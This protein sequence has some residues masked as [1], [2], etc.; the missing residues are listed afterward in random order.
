M[1]EIKENSTDMKQYIWVYLKGVCMGVADIIPGVSGGT[2]AFITGIYERLI[3]AIKSI[4]F[5]NLKLLFTGKIKQFWKNVD[6]A[7]LLCVVSG[8]A[9]S[10]L[11]LVH[12]MTYLLET[13]PILVWSFFLGLVLASTFFV[14]RGVKW[15][16]KTV[17]AF[18]L[19]CVA[20][21][22]LTSPDNTPISSTSSYWYIF[23]CGAIAVCVM[24]LPGV[25]GGFILVLLGQ[26]YFM[27]NALKNFDMLVILTFVSG[28]LIGVVS[29]SNVLSWLLKHFKMITLASLA[30]FMLGSL[31]KLYP[32]KHTLTTYTDKEGIIRPLTEKNVLPSNFETLTGNDS[33]FLYAILLMLVGFSLVFVIEF[34]SLKFKKDNK[35]QTF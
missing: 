7:F 30:G 18:V 21:F 10:F 33:Q 28:A 14:G 13:Q 25:S 22:F 16:W 9:T 20:A 1:Q 6:A 19:L 31:N 27:L 5:K 3:Q 32:W 8:I 35:Q 17:L 29:F 11:T 12:L 26:Y 15:N 34:I 24:I 2:I 23:L 4:N